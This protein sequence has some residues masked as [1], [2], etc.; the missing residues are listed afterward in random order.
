M[1]MMIIPLLP[2]T[3]QDLDGGRHHLADVIEGD[4]R[5]GA[6]QVH[7]DAELRQC[8]LAAQQRQKDVRLLYK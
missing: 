1:M 7:G 3:H 5:L 4:G 2:N 6:R 8:Q